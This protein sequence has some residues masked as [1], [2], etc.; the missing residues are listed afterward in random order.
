MRDLQDLALIIE[1]HI[2]LVVLETHDEHHAL[3]LLTRVAL[4][5]GRGLCSWSITQGLQ[6]AILELA[7]DAGADPEEPLDLLRAIKRTSTP[8]IF[9]VFDFHPYMQGNPAIV[10]HI[11]DIALAYGRLA[12][13]IIF[14]SHELEL[15]AEIRRFSARFD[16]SF[17]GARQLATILREEISAWM[18][19][20]GGH[21]PDV[22]PEAL[23]G[24]LGNLKGVTSQDARRLLR[25]AIRDDGAI[26]GED[27]VQLN[28]SRFALLGLDGLMSFE[29]DTC[30]LDAVAG[31]DKLKHWLTSRKTPFWITQ[32]P[33]LRTSQ[34]AYC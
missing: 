17:P 23:Q 32:L 29:D 19:D 12:H 6:N 14:V 1:S 16:L 13:T 3:N 20:H 27:V 26:T 18:G 34:R 7:P 4:K 33:L 5:T 24:L 30:K 21:R 28:K 10:R 8:S 15:P 22:D 25:A 31:L 9:I 11:K 2:P